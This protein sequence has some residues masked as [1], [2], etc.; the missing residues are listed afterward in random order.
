MEGEFLYDGFPPLRDRTT[1]STLTASLP[2]LVSERGEETAALHGIHLHPLLK[3][4]LSTRSAAEEALATG[5]FPSSRGE[6]RDSTES[7][8][9]E[10][11]GFPLK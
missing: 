4:R 9:V 1:F 10:N 11:S 7:R 8:A 2:D 3:E 6:G 5:V